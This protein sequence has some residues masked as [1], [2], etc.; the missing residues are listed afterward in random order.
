MANLNL[1]L[2]LPRT[3]CSG[4]LHEASVPPSPDHPSKTGKQLIL[5]RASPALSKGNR[6]LTLS[7]RHVNTRCTKCV[8]S[9][10]LLR[11]QLH[12][13]FHSTRAP[14]TSASSQPNPGIEIFSS[15]CSQ[16]INGTRT[17][18]QRVATEA[19]KRQMHA[20]LCSCH[21]VNGVA[22]TAPLPPSCIDEC[23]DVK[24][25]GCAGPSQPT[26]GTTLVIVPGEL[27][28][29]YNDSLPSALVARCT[30]CS[31]GW[32]AL[33]N[34]RKT[35]LRLKCFPSTEVHRCPTQPAQLH[36]GCMALL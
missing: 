2:A 7:L 19:L 20:H 24:E 36:L 29:S 15:F 14:H 25:H 32:R 3:T 27:A 1:A 9:Q 28:S 4:V 11:R 6:S 26:A 8:P 30:V 18:M 34:P 5:R 13:N 10:T 23:A 16:R 31:T 17:P 35:R 22:Y 21:D 12:S 33:S